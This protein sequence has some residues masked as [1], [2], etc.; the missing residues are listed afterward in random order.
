MVKNIELYDE[1]ILKE[2]NNKLKNYHVKLVFQVYAYEKKS[3]IEN[4]N[5]KVVI[6]EYIHK[7]RSFYS[8]I[9]ILSCLWGPLCEDCIPI[10]V[11][12]YREFM[13]EYSNP[14]DEIF[15][16]YLADTIKKNNCAKYM[17]LY[18]DLLNDNISPSA[19]SIIEMVSLLDLNECESIL[20]E[21][22]EKENVI[23]E[24]W[25]GK[26][27]EDDKYYCSLVA[28][29]CLQKSES[30]AVKTLIL[31]WKKYDV[32]PWI[33]F[34]KSPDYNYLMKTTNRKYIDLLNKY[35]NL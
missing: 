11:S 23:P 29:K 19:G 2:M 1:N 25:K 28:L 20:L 5:I 4:E 14:K 24:S 26:L 16:Q 18:I 27:N 10:L 22:V 21:L 7:F 30:S 33:K 6:L 31:E 9:F 35:H 32:M 8:K 34:E 13:R 12:S 17:N 3:I 15:C